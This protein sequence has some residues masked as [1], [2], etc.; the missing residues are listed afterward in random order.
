[1]RIVTGLPAVPVS[2]DRVAHDHV[3]NLERFVTENPVSVMARAATE[4]GLALKALDQMF[5]ERADKQYTREL[6]SSSVADWMGVGVEGVA[7]SVYAAYQR[8]AKT[9]PVSLAAVLQEEAAQAKSHVQ[10]PTGTDVGAVVGWRVFCNRSS[11]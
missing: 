10:P 3:R 9:L 11:G 6:L 4:N 1:Y 5:A 2:G 7:A 8:V